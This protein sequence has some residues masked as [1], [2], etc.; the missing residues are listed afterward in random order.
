MTRRQLVQKLTRWVTSCGFSECYTTERK[1]ET[2]EELEV[3]FYRLNTGRATHF[4]IIK[5]YNPTKVDWCIPEDMKDGDYLMMDPA[6]EVN[7]KSTRENND[8]NEALQK[9][10]VRR[11]TWILMN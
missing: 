8:G 4:E 7:E 5:P 9:K 3:R 11:W 1:K 2:P 6:F 10:Q